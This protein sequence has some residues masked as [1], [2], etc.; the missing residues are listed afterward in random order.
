MVFLLHH[1]ARSRTAIS[2][3]ADRVPRYQMR[4]RKVPMDFTR[5]FSAIQRARL[6][7]GKQFPDAHLI[8]DDGVKLEW[9][10]AWLHLRPS[11]TESLIRII[12]EARSASRAD[13][14]VETGLALIDVN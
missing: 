10:D 9:A 3:L 8:L 12:A 6:A 2:T 13:S 5:V 14:L 7:A 1:M 4:K 11:N